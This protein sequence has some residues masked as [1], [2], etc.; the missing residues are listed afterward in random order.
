MNLPII[1]ISFVVIFLFLNPPKVPGQS[2]AVGLARIDLAGC[3]LFIPAVF[4]LLFAMQQGGQNY[5]W[6][7]S[8]IIGLFVGSGVTMLIFVALE[9]HK[10]SGAMIPV[11]V[12]TRRTVSFAVGF[13]FCHM[14]SLTIATYYL[15]QWFQTVEGVDPLQSGVRYLP[16]VVTQIIMTLTASSL[17]VKLKYYNPWFFLA[18]LFL[19][20]ASALYTTFTVASTPSSHWIGYQVIQGVAGGWGMQM[21]SLAVQ[22]ELKDSPDLLP[23][24]IALVSF[25]QYLGASVVQVIAG[26]VFNNELRRQLSQTAHLSSAQMS[27]LLEA[28]TSSVRQVAEQNFPNLLE[29]ILESYN[30]AITRAFFV[31]LAGSGVAFFLAFGIKWTKVE[32]AK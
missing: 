7:S 8:T 31:P 27:M 25:M 29:P 4:M 2:I 30:A 14:G 22:L 12:V 17:A 20:T 15:P 18:P 13:A 9:W 19:V 23:V 10:G 28:G 6:N 5:A 32:G 3:A 1:A 26:A 11:E 16:T 24:G 21:S